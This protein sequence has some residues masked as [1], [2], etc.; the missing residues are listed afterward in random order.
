MISP[1]ATTSRWTSRVSQQEWI[2]LLV[3]VVWGLILRCGALP[4]LAI[5]HFDE[6]VYASNIWFTPDEGGE[7]PARH[8][9]AP[10]GWPLVLEL[11]QIAAS[12]VGFSANSLGAVL[13]GLAAGMMLVLASWIIARRAFGPAAGI[14]VAFLVAGNDVL[15]LYSQTVLTDI[16]LSLCGLVA[17]SCFV[18]SIGAPAGNSTGGIIDRWVLLAAGCA[19]AGWWVKYNGWLV[20]AMAGVITLAATLFPGL[21]D[22]TNGTRVQ[23]IRAWLKLGLFALLVAVLWLPVLYQLQ[24]TG[25]YLAVATNHAG[26][27][28]GW[29]SWW[30]NA[31]RQL[32]AM[33]FQTGASTLSSI[34]AAA[35][36][37]GAIQK[38]WQVALAN[39]ALCVLFASGLMVM[40]E[41]VPGLLAAAGIM[42]LLGLTVFALRQSRSLSTAATLVVI[43]TFLVL[44][45][46]YYPYPRLAL[47]LVLASLFLLGQLLPAIL[48]DVDSQSAMPLPRSKLGLGTSLLLVAAAVGVSGAAVTH[49][50]PVWPTFQGRLGVQSA[51]REFFGLVMQSANSTKPQVIYVIGEPPLFFHLK[52]QGAFAA[53]LPSLAPLVAPLAP[54]GEGGKNSRSAEVADVWFVVGPHGRDSADIANH[55]L[56]LGGRAQLQKEVTVPVSSVVTLDQASP[57][58]LVGNPSLS[59]SVYSLWR[60]KPL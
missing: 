17:L 41:Q 36:A 25:G 33:L 40:A 53:V 57:T 22:R 48:S 58:E 51:A 43:W 47:P 45:P 55:L 16:P 26:Y 28:Q 50:G 14:A 46:I 34:V 30:Q 60:L 18:R 20:V 49:R 13:V 5:E 19:G 7:F 15:A 44:V 59:T 8:L 3:A 39:G 27:V 32:S 9:Y 2:V 42:L 52:E 35:V 54:L 1:L 24:G 21:R 38:N 31:N 23:P 12:L 56:L 29:G 11:G 10:P 6:G 37:V 4:W